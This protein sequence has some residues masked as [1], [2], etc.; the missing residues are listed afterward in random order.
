MPELRE[1]PVFTIAP[2]ALP[3]R[4]AMDE[5]KLE[6]LA[7]SMKAIGLVQPI[8]V[9]AT[10]DGHEIVAGH[11]RYMAATRLGWEKVRCVVYGP[12]ELQATA[13]M[14]AE[15]I[16]REDLTAAEEALW[17]TQLQEQHG[18]DTIGLAKM[19]GQCQDY[20]EQRLNLFRGD[21]MVFNALRA[22]EINFS[23]ARELNRFKDEGQR[24]YHLDAAVR[25]GATARMVMKWRT[26]AEL[27]TPAQITPTEGTAP[28]ELPPVQPC[29]LPACVICGGSKD[30]YNLVPVVIH[31]HCKDHIERVINE[32]AQA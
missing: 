11:R 32:S 22:R 13:A 8:T 18:V 6:E 24:R 7:E 10:A 1:I 19:V 9:K 2:P 20:V 5:Q 17:F 30:Q 4:E 26:D 29:E 14:L 15:N 16:H 3:V 27:Y 21:E 23:V 31:R 12:E 28:Q 25:T